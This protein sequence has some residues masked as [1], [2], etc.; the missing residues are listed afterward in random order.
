VNR[1]SLV[2]VVVRDYDEA[3]GF[4]VGALGFELVEDTQLSADKRWVVVAP[5]DRHDGSGL[6]LARAA[7]NAQRAHIGDQ[8][9]GRVTFFLDTDDLDTDLERLRTN[10]VR[11]VDGPRVDDYGRV[12]VFE[13][14]Y[15][16]RWDLV[17]RAR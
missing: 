10:G 17:E 15:G 2:T 8:T 6:L 7:T 5:G 3:I 14:L 16:N 13:D 12:V 11:V 9:G 1:L 4:Y